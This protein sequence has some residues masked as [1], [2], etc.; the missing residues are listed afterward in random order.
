MS[1]A[2]GMDRVGVVVDVVLML[3]VV[4]VSLV[5]GLQLKLPHVETHCSSASH[6]VSVHDV[7]DSATHIRTMRLS[8]SSMGRQWGKAKNVPLLLPS[9]SQ[10]PIQEKCLG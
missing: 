2:G 9:P 3:L 10:L 5:M 6:D 7:I 4:V 1:A 8:H